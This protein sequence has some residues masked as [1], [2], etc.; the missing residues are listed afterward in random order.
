MFNTKALRL[1]RDIQK[2]KMAFFAKSMANLFIPYL[3]TSSTGIQGE[4]VTK[5][6]PSKKVDGRY[7]TKK[8]ESSITCLTR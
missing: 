6:T 4:F 1:V 3:S 5:A 2:M 8:S 7:Y